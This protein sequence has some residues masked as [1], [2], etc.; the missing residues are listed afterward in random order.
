[1]CVSIP[2]QITD[3]IDSAHRIALVDISGQPRTINL[4]LLSADEGAV[5]DW[6]LVHAG[7]AI[8]H[9]DATDAHTI[10]AMLRA[11]DQLNQEERP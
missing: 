7:L 2:G 5:G 6:V 1:M 10:L 8:S 4:G 9:V 11:C 3:I